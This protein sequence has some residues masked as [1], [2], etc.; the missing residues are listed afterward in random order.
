MQLDETTAWERLRASD[1]GVLGTVHAERGIDLVPVV[2]AIDDNRRVFVPI[3]RVKAK[4][5]TRLQRLEN[6][7][8]DSRCTLLAEHYDRIDWSR[9]W[10]VRLNGIGREA[11]P[12]DLALFRPLLAAR[13]RQYAD[14]AVVVGGL[15]IEDAKVIGWIAHESTS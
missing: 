2:F 15:V 8:A 1:H 9:L 7:A 10:W 11:S 3:D 14:P 4:T 12:A 13:Y 5:T 6:L